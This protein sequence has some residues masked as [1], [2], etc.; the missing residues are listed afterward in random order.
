[1]RRDAFVFDTQWPRDVR[2]EF[3]LNAEEGHSFES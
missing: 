1:M 2:I 3:M